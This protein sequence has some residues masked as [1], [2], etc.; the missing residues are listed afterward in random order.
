VLDAP[1]ALGL[2]DRGEAGIALGAYAL[3]HAMFGAQLGI[4][5]DHGHPTVF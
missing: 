3:Q 2:E 1:V 5:N 4:S